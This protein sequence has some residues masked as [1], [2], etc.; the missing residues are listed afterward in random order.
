M[1][2][3]QGASRCTVSGE[4]LARL[5]LLLQV[6]KCRRMLSGVMAVQ[7]SK[8]SRIP[9][10]SGQPAL[11]TPAFGAPQAVAHGYH[12]PVTMTASAIPMHYVTG[13]PATGSSSAEV[14]IVYPH[15][16]SSSA[17]GAG[18][19][20]VLWNHLAFGWGQALQ[21]FCCLPEY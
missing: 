10:G 8:D 7:I 15:F 17:P 9:G 12:Q 14:P 6:L 16:I 13:I 18:P 19:P 5:L 20:A 3:S 11:V 1:G 4:L 2:T 21:V